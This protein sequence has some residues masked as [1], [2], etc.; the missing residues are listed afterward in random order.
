[1]KQKFQKQRI[2]CLPPV[3]TKIVKILLTVATKIIMML[4]VAVVNKLSPLH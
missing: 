4:P 3:A 1:M 2:Y